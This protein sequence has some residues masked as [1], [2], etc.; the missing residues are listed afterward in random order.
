M[1]VSHSALNHFFWVVYDH[2]GTGGTTDQC[3]HGSHVSGTFL[4]LP[5]SSNLSYS[6]AAPR[7]GW[8]AT[9][10]YRM[11]KE[12]RPLGP[13]CSSVGTSLSTLYANTR[14]LYTDSQGR[15]T[16]PNRIVNNSWGASPGSSA[17]VGSELNARLTDNQALTYNQL[18]VFSSGNSG[19]GSGTVGLPA[20]AKNAFT[21]GNVVDYRTTVGDPG[22]LWTSSS[23]GPC[24]DGRWK[25]N[26]VAPGRWIR[27]VDASGT[28]GFRNS[29]GTSMAAPHVSGLAAQLV[30]HYSWLANAPFRTAS[31]L[32]AT[33]STKNNISIATETSTHL[34][35]YGT[36]RVNGQ[37]AHFNE[38]DWNWGAWWWHYI[39]SFPGVQANFTVPSGATRLVVCLT[40]YEPASSSGASRALVNDLDLWVD[41]PPITSGTNTGEYFAQQS[42]RDTTEIRHILNPIAGTWRFK[43]HPRTFV[44]GST[45]KLGVTVLVVTSDQSPDMTL[46]MN[47]SDDYVKPNET[48][49]ITATVSPSDYISSAVFVDTQ[50]S[51]GASL[52]R[53]RT[54][55]KDNI[56]TNLLNNQHS[57]FDVTLGDTE[58]DS[59]RSVI[60]TAR[61]S[62]EGVKTYQ[63]EA[64]SD[65]STNQT[66]STRVTVDGTAPPAP[67]NLVST[68]HNLNG[69]KN[70]RTMG[71]S[72][73]QGTDN[74]SG[75]DGHGEGSSTSPN[76][77][78]GNV[79][80]FGAATSRTITVPSDGQWHYSLNTVDRSGNWSPHVTTGPYGIDTVDPRLVTNLRSTSHTP[81]TWSRD[82][83]VDFAWTPAIDDRSG[84][85]GYSEQA[86]T[87]AASPPLSK[88]MEE[89]VTTRTV[90]LSSN[91]SAWTYAMRTVDNAG[92]WTRTFASVGNILIDA[93]P[94]SAVTNLASP[95]HV[96]NTWSSDPSVVANWTPATDAHSGLRTYRIE[97][98]HSPTTNPN[99][100]ATHIGSTTSV[101]QTLASSPSGWYMHIRAIDSA[102]N[103]GPT[104]HLGPFQIDTAGP[105][106]PTNLQSTTHTPN[107]WSNQSNINMTWTAA[108]DNGSGVAGY[109]SVFDAAAGTVPAGALNLAAGV[110]SEGATLVSSA[111]GQ[112][113]HLRARDIAGTFGTT[114]HA[115]PYLIDTQAPTGVSLLIDGGNPN[116]TTVNVNLTI[117][118]SDA[119]S[120]LE[121]MRFR[122]DGG[123]FTAW[124][125][126]NAA[127]ALDLTAGGGSAATG[128]RTVD[129]EVRDRAGNVSSASD[130]IYYYT[131]VEYFGNAC[132]GSQGIPAFVVGGT[133]GL[134]Q[135]VTFT[136]ANT[137]APAATLFLGFSDTIWNGI[138]IPLDLALINVPGCFVNVSLDIPIF[139]GPPIPVPIPIP[140]DPTIVGVPTFYQWHLYGDPSGKLVVTTRGAKVVASGL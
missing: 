134:G 33:A 60:W 46:S 38:T 111:S 52:T 108:T 78:P 11:I 20:V 97:W 99:G 122:N 70:T 93:V 100:P 113:Y 58:D 27:S 36:G 13:F 51:G 62:T 12:F 98:D 137:A 89:N 68:T 127:K 44:S 103:Y 76:P 57:G 136:V 85:D 77:A 10:R 2:V 104:A 16:Q 19:S 17:W 129:V 84:V 116:A 101:T 35:E 64:R 117:G 106:G 139:S 29:S 43:V 40:Y 26:V 55:L 42:T 107:V 49:D 130:S 124:E 66:A 34:D 3:G 32:Q 95:S 24:G 45:V 125:P 31:L 65:N 112:Y 91:A 56:T 73:S 25:P 50:S 109:R 115:G 15:T 74:L 140:V 54:T 61:W 59:P 96:V 135:T 88:A 86:T 119:H 9:A 120:G 110:T 72:W 8:G 128:T 41:R 102:G 23:R 28:T 131:P 4:G 30:D 7:C 6:G 53:S 132:A 21:V 94:P 18:L 75:V 126:F 47:S 82:T 63:A 121:S 22:S 69:W 39:G 105:Q 71:F 87:G 81:G 48:V 114:A 133:P 83:T 90:T 1:R 138:P 67:S 80:D 14:T 92:N 79:K 123:A 5:T 37:R 118:G